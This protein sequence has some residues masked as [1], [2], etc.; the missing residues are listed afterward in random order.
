MMSKTEATAGCVTFEE[1]LE[2]EGKF[3]YTNVGYS[4]M[5]LLRQYKDIIEITKKA[6]GRC[7]KYD[8]VLYK[9]GE[10]YVLH[11]ILK[12]L[13]DGYLIAGDHCKVVERD[14]K[15]TNILGVM[16]RVNRNGK[17]ITPD[18]ILY[19]AYVHLW[20]DVYPIRML[21][22]RIKPPIWSVLS[23]VKRMII[24]SKKRTE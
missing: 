21:L 20:C 1:V 9:R 18:N 7:K 13:P 24:G 10:K 11:R 17:D 22:L 2:R 19:K 23:K 6:P 14:I 12:V 15:D 16:T 3:V 8:V 5:P 4:M